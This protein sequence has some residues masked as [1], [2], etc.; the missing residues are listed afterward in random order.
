MLWQWAKSVDF[1]KIFLIS[2]LIILEPINESLGVLNIA[3]KSFVK[4]ET[5]YEI[6]LELR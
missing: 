5:D 4:V 3:T 6:L 1:L 2:L